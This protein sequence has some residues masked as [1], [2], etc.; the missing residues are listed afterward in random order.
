MQLTN[1]LVLVTAAIG[2]TAAPAGDLQTRSSGV[3][4]CKTGGKWKSGWTGAAKSE[5]YTCNNS[6]L[7]VSTFSST[8]YCKDSAYQTNTL[9]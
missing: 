4:L 6:G 2:A 7:V 1:F 8:F 5:Q 3:K 9:P